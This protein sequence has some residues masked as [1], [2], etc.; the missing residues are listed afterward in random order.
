M[1]KYIVV[2]QRKD[3]T[4]DIFDS[5]FDTI[6]EANRVAE[7]DWGYLTASE[8]A[9]RHIFVGMLTEDCLSDWAVDE[10]SGEVDWLAW[11]SIY[12]VKGAFD[13]NN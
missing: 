13:S 9:S 5:I 12:S 3:G 1:K 10:D 8:K 4:G 7:R 6:E 2:D 11:N